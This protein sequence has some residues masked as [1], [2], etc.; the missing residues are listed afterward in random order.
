MG[1]SMHSI[2]CREDHDVLD[3]NLTP[4]LDLMAAEHGVSGTFIVL[5]RVPFL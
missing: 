5:F 1:Q 2:I 4:D 3:K